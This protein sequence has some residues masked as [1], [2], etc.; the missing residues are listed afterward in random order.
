M[1]LKSFKNSIKE[2]L[3]FTNRERKAILF[4]ISIIVIL[5]GSLAYLKFRPRDNIKIDF[6]EFEKEI[7]AFEK[8]FQQDS[9]PDY[10]ENFEP[11]SEKKILD[12]IKPSIEISVFDFNPNN[13]PDS[14]W[15]KLGLKER[16]VKTIK[17]YEAKGGKFYKKEDLKKIYGFDKKNYERLE[18][19]IIIPVTASEAHKDSSFEKPE[20]IFH[21]TAQPIIAFDLN[22][23]SAEELKS[24][25]GIGDA[26]ANSIVKYRS[27]LGGYF[28]KE[29]LLEAYG[30]DSA[31]YESIKNYLEV[32]TKNLISININTA[33]EP[34]LRHP[35]ISK[36]L[37]VVVVNYRKMHG[38]YDS[39]EEIKKLPLI[40]D[41]LYRKLAP[42]LTIK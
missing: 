13:L 37:A 38:N 28:Y 18:P 29:Q 36:Q 11:P 3:T 39:V 25:Y 31:L 9:N 4:L 19:Y 20:K 5:L 24:L 8:Q 42:Y 12:E 1:P 33:Y 6:S 15:L 17:K 2:Y 21:K 7:D 14:L 32:K 40:N 22:S 41:E 35:Y 27:L 16:I 26:K 30:I 23:V 10:V 34:Q